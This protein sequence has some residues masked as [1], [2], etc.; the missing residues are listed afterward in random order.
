MVIG[1]HPKAINCDGCPFCLTDA[2]NRDR[3]RC[4]LTDEVLYFTKE[5][6]IRCPLVKEE[7]N[8]GQS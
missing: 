1:F 8:D 3:K 4:V 2:F 5:M 7:Q 6:G